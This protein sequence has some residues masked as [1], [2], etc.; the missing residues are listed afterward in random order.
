MFR[1]GFVNERPSFEMDPSWCE[2]GDRYMLKLFRDYVFHQEDEEGHPILDYA[3]IVACL[4]KLDAGTQEKILLVARDES[5][6]VITTYAEIKRCL[7]ACMNELAAAQ[8]G[9][10]ELQY[11]AWQ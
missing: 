9:V 1:L 2:T 11:N 7:Q 10:A 3:H 8:K 4:N 6:M 5:S